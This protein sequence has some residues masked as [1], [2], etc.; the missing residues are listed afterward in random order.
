MSALFRESKFFFLSHFRHAASVASDII[1]HEGWAALI[2]KGVLY[3]FPPILLIP[4]FKLK[5]SNLASYSDS[6]II[7]FAYRFFW[8]FLKPGQVKSEISALV[9][10]VRKSNPKTVLE[11][12]T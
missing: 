4:V 2:K 1:H 8:G 3:Y 9:N 7:S 11:I 12:G 10:I 6:K 5:T